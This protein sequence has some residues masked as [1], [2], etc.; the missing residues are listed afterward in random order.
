MSALD[1]DR[2]RRVYQAFLSLPSSRLPT[3]PFHLTPW[4]RINDPIWFNLLR[5]E[6]QAAI[7]YLEGRADRPQPRQRTDALLATLRYLKPLL[8][9]ISDEKPKLV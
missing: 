1:E 8:E 2:E 7:D 6:V 4:T 9:C 5:S 3:P